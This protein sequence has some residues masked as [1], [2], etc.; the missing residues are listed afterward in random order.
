MFIF[1]EKKKA[2]KEGLKMIVVTCSHLHL[3]LSKSQSY[4]LSPA[5]RV[6]VSG[7]TYCSL[8]R[9][10]LCHFRESGHNNCGSSAFEQR[11]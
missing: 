8:A 6:L 2:R 9:T 3:R 5:L 10:F 4:T 11:N 7:T 1:L